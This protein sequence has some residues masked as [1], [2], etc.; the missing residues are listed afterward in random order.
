MKR[1]KQTLKIKC[2]KENTTIIRM[3]GWQVEHNL[4]HSIRTC[5][6]LYL[7]AIKHEL[8]IRKIRRYI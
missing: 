7:A 1:I 6:V 2:E 8:D 3:R 4:Q 5:S